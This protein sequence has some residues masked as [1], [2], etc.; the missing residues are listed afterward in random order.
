MTWNHAHQ[1]AS[2]PVETLPWPNLAA[3][4]RRA[5]CAAGLVLGLSPWPLFTP[6]NSWLWGLNKETF[7]L[8]RGHTWHS[9]CS[10]LSVCLSSMWPGFLFL[11]LQTASSVSLDTTQSIGTD[12]LSQISQCVS[13]GKHVSLDL[14]YL[15]L[16]SI[17]WK[18]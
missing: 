18:T 16:S 12:S 6:Y 1:I 7:L 17:H 5:H 9:H 8:P 2:L 11:V 13:S 10:P 3:L 14:V 15:C 4:G